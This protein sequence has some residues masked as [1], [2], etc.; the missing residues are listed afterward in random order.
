MVLLRNG[1]RE[2][3]VKWKSTPTNFNWTC[4]GDV[5]WA[6]A[7]KSLVG[8]GKVSEFQAVFPEINHHRNDHFSYAL[9]ASGALKLSWSQCI[10]KL[11]T[12]KFLMNK[13]SQKLNILMTVLVVYMLQVE[14]HSRMTTG[15]QSRMFHAKTCNF[16]FFSTSGCTKHF[17]RST[18]GGKCLQYWS[19]ADCGRRQ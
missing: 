19:L 4:H 15:K 16:Q 3:L 18:E 11:Y 13:G 12:G 5:E 14:M 8:K 6:K 17:I 9:A 7:V 2:Q 1:L 10:S